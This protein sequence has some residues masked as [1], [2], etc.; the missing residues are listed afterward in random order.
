M[1][2]IGTAFGG[3]P[4]PDP[5]AQFLG[6]VLAWSATD[7]PDSYVNIHGFTPKDAV[8]GRQFP[9]KGGGRAFGSM[10]EYQQLTQFLWMLDRDG[11]EVFFCISTR[12][13]HKG[14]D[15]QGNKKATRAK[16][17][18]RPVRLKAFVL[19]LDV[20]PKGYPSQRAALAA[21]LPFL[22]GFGIRPGPIVDTGVGLH[23]YVT[24]DQ[25][26]TP[27]QWQPLANALIEATRQAGVKFDVAV[28][29]DDDRIL[30][31]PTSFNRKD[32]A[33]PK[34]CRILTLGHDTALADLEKALAPYSGISRSVNEPRTNG[35][36]KLDLSFL[37]PRPPITRGPDVDRLRAER[38]RMRVVTSPG[39]LLEECPVT[40]DSLWRG[41]DGDREPLWFELAKLCHY[42][43]EG[44]EFFHELSAKDERYDEDQTDEKFDIAE[45]QGWP[46]CATIGAA[47]E[48]A[49][50]ICRACPHYGEGKSPLHFATRGDPPGEAQSGQVNGHVN[51]HALSAGFLTADMP[52]RPIW[53]PE[54]YRYENHY[55]LTPEGQRCFSAPIL[56]IRPRYD[57]DG[58]GYAMSIEFTTLRGTH[59]TDDTNTFSVS[60][61]VLASRVKTAEAMGKYGLFPNPLQ[62]DHDTMTDIMTQVRDRRLMV[63]RER[64]GWNDE[65][66]EFYFGGKVY[67]KEGPR[68]GSPSREPY[69]E[70][71][72]NLDEWKVY[73]NH[74]VGRGL[75]EMETIM[76]T[77]Y[78]GPL[79]PFS[80]VD[81]VFLYVW[82][83]RSGRGKSAACAVACSVSCD[84]NAVVKSNTLKAGLKRI[85]T[86]NNI[87]VFFD[88]L[89]LDDPEQNR[90]LGQT[91]KNTVA[92]SDM[93]RL[94]RMG[95]AE[96]ETRHS[97]NQVVACG[98]RRVTEVTRAVETNSQ[99]AR[100]VEFEISDA[101][102]KAGFS[103]AEVPRVKHGLEHNYGVAMDV[104][105]DH[106]ARHR[107]QI[108]EAITLTMAWLEGRLK[109][110]GDVRFWIA[111]MAVIIVAA[112]LAKLL[113]LQQ[114]DVSAIQK[115]LC[116]WCRRRH[117]DVYG[118]DND[119]D[120]V[121][122]HMQRIRDFYNDNMRTRLLTPHMARPGQ[123]KEKALN[124]E[125]LVGVGP[126]E[127][128]IRIAVEDKRMF[129]SAR[130]FKNWCYK[131]EQQGASFEQTKAVLLQGSA[132]TYER[133][134]KSIGGGS[135]YVTAQEPVLSFDLSD[136]RNVGFIEET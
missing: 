35:H 54:K 72:G 73:A 47:S 115:F 3:V 38:E 90:A 46:A 109:L 114:F 86:F 94:R 133:K 10:L 68:P 20:K 25:P 32:P 78:T 4:M 111:Q 89:V 7:P 58:T 107:E 50:R 125:Q 19:D 60:A 91:I 87:P 83:G 127:L 31:L 102:V 30:R 93:L 103:Q 48:E 119:A 98:N 26:I 22:D 84:P 59:D 11:D 42:V 74:Y 131:Y 9:R 37:P 69:L 41:G 24:L 71:A 13:A 108:A 39:L 120:T 57:H 96:Q 70:P 16:A 130:K 100:V 132:C 79:V 121:E 66:T 101:L 64:T 6:R 76:A 65:S 116:D 44:R 126:N 52:G 124:W 97:R 40:A 118:T 55:I 123:R 92:G 129:L 23:V 56:N 136:P 14:V 67:T 112:K 51:G 135:D 17:L 28:T 106:V 36:A 75:V 18:N 29:R 5:L 88:E 105:I 34:L 62:K 113:G 8:A 45:P 80:G 1:G 122:F 95:D 33:N 99:A 128:S 85:V 117:A 104:Y 43:E 53:L 61:S 77:G 63:T 21:V 49:E 110:R 81:G 2:E 12:S 15:K 82:S 134:N 27:A